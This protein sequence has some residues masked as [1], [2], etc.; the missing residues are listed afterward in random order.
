VERE[1]ILK[2]TI[3]NESFHETGNDNGVI[4]VNFATSKNLLVK[5]TIFPHCR[6]H[7]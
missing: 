6:I 4:A 7:K 1:G 3:G 5:S 2:P